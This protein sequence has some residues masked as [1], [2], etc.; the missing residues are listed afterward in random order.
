MTLRRFPWTLVPDLPE[1]PIEAIRAGQ[2]V[3]LTLNGRRSAATTRAA[4]V[5]LARAIAT[6][7]WS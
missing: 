7:A 5:K 2:A 6:G 4:I 1:D 3:S